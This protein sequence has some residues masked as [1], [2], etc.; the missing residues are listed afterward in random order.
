MWGL[1]PLE[2]NMSDKKKNQFTL[3]GNVKEIRGKSLV[4]FELKL[5]EARNVKLVKSIDVFKGKK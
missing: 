2:V 5:Q 3:K 4:E 1:C